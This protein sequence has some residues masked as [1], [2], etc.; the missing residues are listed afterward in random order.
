[1]HN[2]ICANGSVVE[3]RLAK[4]RVASSNLVSRLPQN[5]AN[6]GFFA[7]LRYLLLVNIDVF[8]LLKPSKIGA[9]VVKI[10]VNDVSFDVKHIPTKVNRKIKG[11]ELLHSR[12]F[13]FKYSRTQTL[14]GNSNAHIPTIPIGSHTKEI[15]NKP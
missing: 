11:R 5:P 12:P 10:V 9:F 2:F 14:S 3:H 1:M 7:V 15:S 4:A 8:S 13:I 6:T